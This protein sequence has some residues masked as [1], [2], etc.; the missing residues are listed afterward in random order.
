MTSIS[1]SPYPPDDGAGRHAGQRHARLHRLDDVVPA[2]HRRRRRHRLRRRRPEPPLPHVHQRPA[3]RQLQRRRPDLVALGRRPRSS[4]TRRRRSRFYAPMIFDPVATK[5]IFVGGQSVWRTRTPAATARSSSST[6][7][8]PSASSARATCS[9]PARAATASRLADARHVDADA[10]RA[11]G[12]T[13]RRQHDRALSRAQDDGTLWAGDP[14]RPRVRLAERERRRPGDGDVHA[15]RHATP[16]RS[17]RLVDLRRPDEPEPRDRH[18]LRLRRRTRRRRRATSSTWCSTR[19]PARR[20]GRTSRTTSA[21]SRSNDAVLDAA[22]GDVYVVDRLRRL[23]PRERDD[24]VDAGRRRPAARWPSPAS[25]SPTAS[26]AARL[27]YAATHGRGAY[28]L[29]LK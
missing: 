5:T 13:K 4:S 27:L 19:P 3:R 7:T 23:P 20:R 22:T 2:A 8:R 10:R 29:R 28:R 6:A 25:R 24:D 26:T 1:V 21:T 16:A 11:F 9:T 12:T 18:V 17:R 14:A 15:D